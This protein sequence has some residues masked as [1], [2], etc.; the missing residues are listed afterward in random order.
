M[1]EATDT[2]VIHWTD[3]GRIRAAQLILMERELNNASEQAWTVVRSICD[4][5]PL[6]PPAQRLN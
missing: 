5:C 1:N 2:L 3:L 6:E 4:A